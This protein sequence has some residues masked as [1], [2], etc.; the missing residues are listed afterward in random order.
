M[1]LTMR[2][3]CFLLATGFVL[4]FLVQKGLALEC[5]SCTSNEDSKCGH[6]FDLSGSE[7]DKYKVQCAGATQACRKLES[8]DSYKGR[9]FVIRSC[10]S[11]LSVEK[12]DEDFLDCTKMASIGKACYCDKELCNGRQPLIPSLYTVMATLLAATLTM[13]FR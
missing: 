12:L 7:A 13:L 3:R 6:S 4:A 1:E 10:W 9:T 5:Y 2:A 8:T 11:S